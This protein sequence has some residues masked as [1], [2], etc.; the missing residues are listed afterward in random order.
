[1]STDQNKKWV[2]VIAIAAALAV[3]GIVL[4]VGAYRAPT[5]ES[6]GHDG[7]KLLVVAATVG[8]FLLLWGVILAIS[9]TKIRRRRTREK[10]AERALKDDTSG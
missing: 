10:L 8:S 4:A 1:M 5:G 3:W 9:A 7:R 6:D 2:P